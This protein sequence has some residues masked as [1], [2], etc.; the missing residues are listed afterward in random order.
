MADQDTETFS[1]TTVTEG[2]DNYQS[3]LEGII[4]SKGEQ[5]FSNVETAL[6]SISNKDAHISTLEEE[7]AKLRIELD[8]R[9]TV[10]AALKKAQEHEEQTSSPGELDVDT[11]A[12][13]VNK[14]LEANK[15]TDDIKANQA[16]VATKLVELWGENA[17]RDYIAIGA[18]VG[19]RPADLDALAGKSPD[20]VFELMGVKAR[21]VQVTK[22]T[23]TTTSGIIENGTTQT[24]ER[25]SVMGVS[26]SKDVM[27]AWRR[28]SPSTD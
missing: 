19:L 14:Q 10:E 22:T 23:S 5:K 20:A 17:E 27:T 2:S 15:T 9:D 1:G 13:I 26:T 6:N 12:Y 8:K 21:D 7:T 11:I 16:T 24:E 25:K 4:N 3:I 18:K 28:C